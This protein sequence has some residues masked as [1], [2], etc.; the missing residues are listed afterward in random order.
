MTIKTKYNIGDKVWYKRRGKIS[1]DTICEMKVNIDCFGEAHIR[2]ILWNEVLR[3]E[4]DIFSTK[5]E[6]LK[7]YNYGK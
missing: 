7:I 3:E 4:N 2:Y 5:E 1:Q 6:L